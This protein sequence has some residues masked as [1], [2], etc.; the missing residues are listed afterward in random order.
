ML[1]TLTQE[2][3][4]HIDAVIAEKIAA[5]AFDGRSV[6]L[7]CERG[8]VNQT[9]VW[10]VQCESVVGFFNA[11]Q[12][13]GKSEYLAIA[14]KIWDFIKAFVIDKRDGSEWFWQV[15]KDGKPDSEKPIVEPWK[16]PY[17]NGR[18]CFEIITRAQKLA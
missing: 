1:Y 11:W 5:I 15:D 17:H 2:Q 9:R 4:S 18:M 14:K 12:K 16:C 10:W 8:K 7:E 13:T 3:L 6:A